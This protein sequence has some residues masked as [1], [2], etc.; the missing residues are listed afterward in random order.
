M[1]NVLSQYATTF[2]SNLLAKKQEAGSWQ[3]LILHGSI[4]LTITSG[5]SYV[6][7]LTRDKILA[8][9]FGASSELDIY[10]AAFVLPD[11]LFA[12]LVSGALSAAF[13]PIFTG[14][15]EKSRT[16]AMLYTNQ[17]LSFTLLFLAV[18]SVIFAIFLPEIAPRLVPGFTGEQLAEYVIV[19]RLMLLTPFFFTISNTFGN[20]LLSTK[21]F[22]W[23]G[24]APVVYNISIVLGALLLVPVF[25]LPGLVVGTVIGAVFHMLVR[26]QAFWRYGF[27]PKLQLLFS[28]EIK[29]TA[30]LML[31][32]MLQIGMWQ[33]MLWWFIQ[34]ASQQ[35]EGSVTRYNFA[36][37]FQSVP[38]SLIGMA[39]AL[40][41]FSTLSH[42]AAHQSYHKFTSI[43]KKESI[44]I[45]AVT[46]LAAVA[47][48]IVSEP[49]IGLLLGGGKF[50][51]EAVVDTAALLKVYAFSVPLE[52]LMHLLARAHYAL[53]NTLRPSI[54]HIFA[55]ICSMV[56]S[57]VLLPHLGLFA[58]PVAFSL[59]FA[60]QSVL[61]GFSLWG[62]LKPHLS[63]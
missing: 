6:L 22:L 57:S 45:L 51:P 26:G 41:S 25:G 60:I 28:T 58:L 54:I 16:K 48:A 62:L 11:F 46:T 40:A 31:P 61:L 42:L 63:K 37:N 20:A 24:L 56:A 55:I 21:D 34:L 17:I 30:R 1:L 15:D 9:T 2:Y 53:K 32:K 10:N 43:V 39:I 27:R 36:Y 13:V 52:S 35:S 14:L 44:K 7:G 47:L 49:L 29:E 3:N 38:V 8:Y 23:Y 50:S 19:T 12:L 18:F 5:M 33:V 59:G 4:I